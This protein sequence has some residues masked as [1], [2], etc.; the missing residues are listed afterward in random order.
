[1]SHPDSIAFCSSWGL[2]NVLVSCGS[3][4]MISRRSEKFAL[5]SESDA[6]AVARIRKIFASR[7]VTLLL[8]CWSA[9]LCN[10]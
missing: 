8:C 5:F 10:W 1:M 9:F 3:S 7:E 4:F 6:G 2:K